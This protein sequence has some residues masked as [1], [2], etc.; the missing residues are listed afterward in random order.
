MR[1]SLAQLGQLIVVFAMAKAAIWWLS[2]L[3]TSGAFETLIWDLPG[4][5]LSE[6][7]GAAIAI[8]ITV[9]LIPPSRALLFGSAVGAF[10]V[11]M[12]GL[13]ELGWLARVDFDWLLVSNALGVETVR[14]GWVLAHSAD[15]L[16][17]W[18]FWLAIMMLISPFLSSAVMILVV[19]RPSSTA[20]QPS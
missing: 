7:A 19:P 3:G 11:L 18:S 15:A 17:L 16:G 4:L 20:A 10:Q 8:L 5:M 14:P 1:P 12:A 2:F 6:F 9:Q 13:I